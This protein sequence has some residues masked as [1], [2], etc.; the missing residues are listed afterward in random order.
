[1]AEKWTQR[2]MEYN[3]SPEVNP[4]KYSHLIFDGRAKEK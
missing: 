3:P 4:H 2:L 1:M